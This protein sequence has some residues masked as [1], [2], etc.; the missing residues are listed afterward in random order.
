[1][2]IGTAVEVGPQTG[3]GEGEGGIL[4]KAHP[5]LDPVKVAANRKNA[6]G[7][8]A[9]S[10]PVPIEIVHEK[11]ALAVRLNT[12]FRP[13]RRGGRIG[14]QDAIPYGIGEG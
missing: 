12:R 14:N 10:E 11:R 9:D 3:G 5:V 4:S 7:K 2:G 1:M 6:A 8:R 13:D